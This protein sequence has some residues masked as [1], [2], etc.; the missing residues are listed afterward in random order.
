MYILTKTLDY[1]WQKTD[2]TSL[3]RGRTNGTGPQLSVNYHLA[4]SP[5]RGSTPRQTDW[6]TVSRKGTLTDWLTDQRQWTRLNASGSVPTPAYSLRP[7][8]RPTRPQAITAL[9]APERTR[10]ASG[11]SYTSLPAFQ[12]RPTGYAQQADQGTASY[13]RAGRIQ[14][15]TQAAP[16]SPFASSAEQC[17]T[18]SEDTSNARRNSAVRA[19]RTY[20][21]FGRTVPD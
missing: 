18:S 1:D 12:L 5:R 9:A 17:G 10:P 14:R 3:Q 8:G 4:M 2:P 13:H 11:R 16:Q 7:A 6:R 21:T 19:V 15:T 20:R